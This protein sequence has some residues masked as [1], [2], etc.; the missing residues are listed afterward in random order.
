MWNVCPFDRVQ[1]VNMAN[2][3]IVAVISFQNVPVKFGEGVPCQRLAAFGFFVYTQLE[4]GKLS[5]PE[6]CPLDSI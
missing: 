4:F 1:L 5:L 6:N 2:S 3:L